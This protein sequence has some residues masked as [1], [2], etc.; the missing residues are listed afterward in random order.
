MATVTLDERNGASPG[1]DT[2]DVANVNFGSADVPALTP[3]S[4]PITAG[5]DVHSYE[6]WLR[7]N[8]T[9]LGE[10]TVV[11][12]IKVWLSNLGGGWK[13]D[14]G[15]SSNAT[16]RDYTAAS[17]PAGGPVNTDSADAVNALPESEPI[18][19]NIGIGGALSGQITAPG[20]SDWI[21]LQLDVS[22]STPSGDVNQKTLTFQWDER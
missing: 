18:G 16:L 5:A 12:N 8:V 9:D 17:Y 14:E 1:V 10:S 19:P 22:A 20:Y 2:A 7:L 13:T 15:I 4:Y 3:A 6:K 11:D 21:V